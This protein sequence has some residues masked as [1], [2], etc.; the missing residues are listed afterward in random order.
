MS[1]SEKSTGLTSTTKFAA[2]CELAAKAT[3]W[4]LLFTALK[5]KSMPGTPPYRSACEKFGLDG[6]GKAGQGFDGD[7]KEFCEE[8]QPFTENGWDDP[9]NQGVKAISGKP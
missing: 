4:F 1:L 7:E 5:K 9:E 3:I 2:P 6:T 8:Y